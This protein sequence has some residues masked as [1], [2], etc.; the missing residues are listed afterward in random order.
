VKKNLKKLSLHRE[1]LR[2]LSGAHLRVAAGG[3]FDADGGFKL[4]PPTSQ[5]T[6]PCT[7]YFSCSLT[8]CPQPAPAPDP[9]PI[10]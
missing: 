8:Y 2:V 9:G 6:C 10:A 3:T 1:T 4:P 5:A 7:D